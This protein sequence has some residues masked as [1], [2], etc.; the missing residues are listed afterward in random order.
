MVL[1]KNKG[2]RINLLFIKRLEVD[3][4]TGDSVFSLKVTDNKEKIMYISTDILEL[5]LK[6][7]FDKFIEQ[8][9]LNKVIKQIKEKT[10]EDFTKYKNIN[11]IMY[12]L[13]T[14]EF[15]DERI[16]EIDVEEIIYNNTERII[17]SYIYDRKEVQ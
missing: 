17:D 5:I 16:F 2:I 11:N 14:K 13:P 7:K 15:E 10:I 4:K 12:A 9:D 8:E 3:T 6:N 1:L